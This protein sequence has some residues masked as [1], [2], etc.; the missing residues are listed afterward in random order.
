ML[1]PDPQPDPRCALAQPPVLLLTRPRDQAE[2]FAAEA[3]AALGPLRVVIAPLV[4]I[5]PRPLTL[6]PAPFAGLIFTSENG[7][8]C[9]GP[10][11][12]LH[13]R[14]A[15]CVGPR[16]AA[17]AAAAGF[18]VQPLAEAGG[19]AEALI[20]SLR[21]ARPA[22]PLLHL[23]GAQAVTDLSG[24]LSA[25]GLACAEAVVYAQ[26]EVPPPPEAL[27]ALSGPAP[28]LLPLFSPASARRAA[29]LVGMA[30]AGAPGVAVAISEAAAARWRAGVA[31]GAAGRFGGWTVAVAPRPDASGMLEA[32][33]GAVG[34]LEA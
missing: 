15:W 8:R 34:R 30:A 11:P 33:E 10:Q 25:E 20:R 32:L 14:P 26:T 24:R 28:V 1:G 22:L 6:D 16:T 18:A 12:A 7:V 3:L 31:K 23:R 2:R 19:D 5:V 4:A 17:A 13:G 27:A 21:A 29:R 9:L